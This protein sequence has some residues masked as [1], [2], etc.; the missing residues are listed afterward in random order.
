MKQQAPSNQF[1]KMYLLVWQFPDSNFLFFLYFMG[2]ALGSLVILLDFVLVIT[3]VRRSRVSFNRKYNSDPHF[4]KTNDKWL[5]ATRVSGV[6]FS[7]FHLLVLCLVMNEPSGE[8]TLITSCVYWV[9]QTIWLIFEHL[10]IILITQRVWHIFLSIHFFFFFKKVMVGWGGGGWN[11]MG[12]EILLDRECLLEYFK[13]IC[14]FPQVVSSARDEI[15]LDAVEYICGDS[16]GIGVG[17]DVANSIRILSAIVVLLCV[18]IIASFFTWIAEKSQKH[19]G[20]TEVSRTVVAKETA[21]LSIILF[22]LLVIIALLSYTLSW[23]IQH[24]HSSLSF[25]APYQNVIGRMEWGIMEVF[26]FFM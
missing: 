7:L 17:T 25:T 9:F 14:A 18:F 4:A 15:G 10:A 21:K 23:Y 6:I 22:V 3:F 2:V 16:A 24:L 12:C 20:F 8:L 19:A 5:K 1:L 11:G 26:G 13:P